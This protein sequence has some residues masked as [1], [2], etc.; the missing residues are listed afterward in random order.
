MMCDF[1][2]YPG[3]IP[4]W[5]YPCHDFQLNVTA[6][7]EDGESKDFSWN[8]TSSWMACE[9]CALM[10]EHNDWKLLAAYTAQ[11]KEL[12]KPREWLYMEF[13]KNRIGV[14]LPCSQN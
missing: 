13:E 5:E 11:V 3:A 12:E 14:R 8:S 2:G 1:C 10:I 7:R 9:P 6:M 4:V